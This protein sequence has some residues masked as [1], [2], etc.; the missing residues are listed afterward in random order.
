MR[1]NINKPPPVFVPYDI[2]YKNIQ[3]MAYGTNEIVTY[4]M[5][6]LPYGIISVGMVIWLQTAI[7]DGYITY[8]YA[9]WTGKCE[10]LSKYKHT[11]SLSFDGQVFVNLMTYIYIKNQ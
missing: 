7:P 9:L 3:D 11:R 10:N 1:T 2:P 6:S 4:G 5:R 8:D